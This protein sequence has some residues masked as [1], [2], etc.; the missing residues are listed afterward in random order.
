MPKA[1]ASLLLVACWAL[2]AQAAWTDVPFSR[3]PAER[4]LWQGPAVASPPRS[5]LGTTLLSEMIRLYQWGISSQDGPVCPMY[6]TCSGFG[7]EAIRRYGALQG[8][9]MTADRLLRDNPSAHTL[10]P[11]TPRGEQLYLYDPV[12]DHVLW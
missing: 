5:D 9:L 3:D 1:F 10:Y 4:K 11:K 2:P 6:P 7:F 8:T 12:E